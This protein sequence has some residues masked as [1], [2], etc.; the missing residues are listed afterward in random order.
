MRGV[1]SFFLSSRRRHTRFDCDWSSDVCS[2]DLLGAAVVSDR[3]GRFCLDHRTLPPSAG[4][5]RALDQARDLPTLLF[6]ER[7]ML[8]DFDA[9][10]D[11]V[12]VRLVVRL[13]AAT[14]LDVLLVQGV[15]LV[16][17]DL[18]HDGLLHLVATDETDQPAD[19]GLTACVFGT[20][21]CSP[22]ADWLRSPRICSILAMSFLALPSRLVSFCWP[23]AFF[24]R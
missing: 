13:V 14:N 23:T 5:R 6:G 17:H 24:I 16:A 22:S 19:P 15:H 20:H 12:L 4:D 7:A 8:D 2:S 9:I 1:T 21:A 18:D 3:E 10:A 11:L